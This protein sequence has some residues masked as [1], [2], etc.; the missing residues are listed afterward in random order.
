MSYV[1]S[2][3]F[4]RTALLLGLITPEEVIA[5]SDE[6]LR[7]DSDPPPFAYTLSLT[8]PELSAVREVLRPV[9]SAAEPPGVIDAVIGLAARDLVSGRRDIDDT[10][11]VLAQLR[12]F[13]RLEAWLYEEIK[14]L[15]LRHMAALGGPS[16]Q[17]DEARSRV[18]EFVA[19]YATVMPL[20][21]TNR[22]TPPDTS[23]LRSG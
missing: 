18:A 19:R 23:S 20:A 3:T 17:L 9:A 11:R 2:A 6:I 5:W 21:R 8:K 22:T 4:L 16:E 10:L 14:A 15:E 12:R 13:L 7:D 1:E